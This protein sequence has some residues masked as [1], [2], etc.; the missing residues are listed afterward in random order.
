M[1]AYTTMAAAV[2]GDSKGEIALVDVEH[3]LAVVADGSGGAAGDAAAG[4]AARAALE[5]LIAGKTV[6]EAFQAA[7]AAAAPKLAA[8]PSAGASLLV[9]QIERTGMLAVGHLGN[10][11]LYVARKHERRALPE[12]AAPRYCPRV[13]AGDGT[14]MVCLTRDHSSVCDM[15]EA[16]HLP[17]DAARRHPLRARVTKGV[18]G[19][20]ATAPDVARVGLYPGDRVVLCTDGLWDSVDD[21][22]LLAPLVAH[23][24]A[25]AASK[26]LADAAD[27]SAHALVVIDCFPS[28]DRDA[29]QASAAGRQGAGQERQGERP[30][31]DGKKGGE[32]GRRG[33]APRGGGRGASKGDGE[34]DERNIL[35]RYGRDLTAQARANGID[36][37]IGR[38]RE[39]Q[40]LAQA[41]LG[42]RK[43]NAVLIGPPGVGKTAI[44]EGLALEMASGALGDR[45]ASKRIVEVPMGALVAGTKYRGDFEERL[46][47][48]I[49]AAEA[50]PE[51]VLFIDELHTAM[52][53]GATGSGSQDAADLLKPALSRG[54]MRLIGATTT[55]EYQAYIA[56]DAAFERRFTVIDVK[57]PSVE[58][59]I[60]ILRGLR[61]SFEKHYHVRIDQE[62]FEAAAKLSKRYITGRYLPDKAID[63]IDRGCARL[64][65]PLDGSRSEEVLRRE[66]V[67]A[68]VADMCDVDV[69]L[70]GRDPREARERVSELDAFLRARIF[71][72]DEALAVIARQLE[73]SYG[74]LKDPKRPIASFMFVGPTG[75]GKTEAAKVVAE[76]LFGDRDRVL[77]ID[78]S[79]YQER[80]HVS[81][82]IGSP[83]GYIGHQEGGQ[84]TSPMLRQGARVVLFDEI[85]KAHPDVLL[86]L[87]QILDEGRLTD[88]HGQTAS[89]HE[90]IVVMT[91]NLLQGG[92]SPAGNRV[93]FRLPG[94]DDAEEAAEPEDGE[95]LA[96]RELARHLRPELVGRIGAVVTFL[97]LSPKA[98][99]AIVDKCCQGA[100]QRLAAQG[101]RVDPPKG[102]VDSILERLGDLRFGARVIERLVNEAVGQLL[103]GT[104]PEGPDHDA[105]VG[106]GMHASMRSSARNDMA[107]LSLSPSTPADDGTLHSL[108]T[109]LC[110]GPQAVQVRHVSV[111]SGRIVLLA[112]SLQAALAIA[113]RHDELSGQPLGR[114]LH[115]GR[116]RLDDQG[117]PS[118]VGLHVL[119]LLVD[120]VTESRGAG[121]LVLTSAAYEA[122]GLDERGG[123]AALPSPALE[124]LGSDI[125]LWIQ[126]SA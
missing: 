119:D 56:R 41:L 66:H 120:V 19:G 46:Q 86:L 107:I 69:E 58:H 88:S 121:Q 54:T 38:Q 110:I 94:R 32:E 103:E 20:E 92:P 10:A 55:A 7:H 30:R 29:A 114:L 82:L 37:V 9:A 64:L 124:D 44:V 72:Q 81:R 42:R 36:P 99:R 25:E 106:A 27:R 123:F 74:G 109:R 76:F 52:G 65:V 108:V 51:L 105:S 93:G 2:R 63:L 14:A 95:D 111:S 100:L 59:T 98:A 4:A 34:K 28:R 62:A 126:E 16:G 21:V 6:E 125:R 48:V 87:L 47:Q 60:E 15:V 5:A 22:D 18:R 49:D 45:F 57:E 116:V 80:H 79:E 77:R 24:H 90:A 3:G 117:E 31:D 11:R 89:F 70:I 122:L 35:E 73:R 84:L 8:D 102:F 12:P 39:I 96:R 78:M 43:A 118:G 33:S 112:A 50:D 104:P 23:D 101:M 83:P 91:S 1:S 67:V 61:A 17:R 68:L 26:K 71:G 40:E 97:S 113:R 13:E 115:R 75:V 53:A 85:E